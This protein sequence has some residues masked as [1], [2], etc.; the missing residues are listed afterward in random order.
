[1][2][3]ATLKAWNLHAK[4]TALVERGVNGEREA[5]R[6]KLARL[7]SRFDF[8][9]PF[10]D[11]LGPDI[12]AGAFKRNVSGQRLPVYTFAPGQM[13]WASSAKWAI[14]QACKIPCAF[15]G[16]VLE[17]ETMP[18][19]ADK[20]GA[21]VRTITDGFVQL[22]GTYTSAP[23]ATAADLPP[24]LAGIYDG[25]MGENRYGERLPSRTG[26]LQPA[27]R[28]LRKREVAVPAGI[29]AHPYTVALHLGK[30][31]R[32]SVPVGEIKAELAAMVNPQLENKNETV[33]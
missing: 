25:M 10:E 5:A 17:A 12:F 22:W 4:L 23:W 3:N 16:L 32:F 14:E 20:L 30:Q 15:N 6:L 8:S 33:S 11:P 7:V 9:K 27:K 29:C 21:V 31:L 19:H 1:M 24:F 18:V 2:K 26:P 13:S 28:K